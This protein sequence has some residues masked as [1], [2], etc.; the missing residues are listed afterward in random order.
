MRT[1]DIISHVGKQPFRPV[2]IFLSDGKSYD[3]GH[4]ERMTVGRSEV[5]I[6]VQSDGDDVFDRFAFCHPVHITRIE[7]INGRRGPHKSK[8]LR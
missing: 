2:R 1:N 4:A 5:V 3:I 8:K 7:P 6:G